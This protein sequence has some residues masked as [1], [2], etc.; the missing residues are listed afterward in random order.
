MSHI[1]NT[2]TIMLPPKE[3]LFRPLFTFIEMLSGK[4]LTVA[5]Q[6]AIVVLAKAGNKVER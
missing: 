3:P 1:P 5:Q 4:A 2:I 6:D